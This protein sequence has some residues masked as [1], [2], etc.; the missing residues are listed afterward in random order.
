[1]RIDADSDEQIQWDEFLDFVVREN[2]SLSS[3]RTEHCEYVNPK[4]ADPPTAIT[5]GGLHTDMITKVVIMP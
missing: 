2:E 1:M 3:M 5:T 4:I